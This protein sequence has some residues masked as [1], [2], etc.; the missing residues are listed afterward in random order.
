MK[1]ANKILSLLLALIMVFSLVACGGGG[2]GNDD[3]KGGGDSSAPPAG[4]TQAVDPTELGDKDNG[5]G[6]YYNEELGYTYGATFKSDTPITFTSFF[7]D[8]DA[9]PLKDSWRTGD[10]VFSKIAELTNVTLDIE[11]VNNASY[12]ERLNLAIS[13][14]DAPNIIPKVYSETAY[15]NG[16]GI[17]PVS[18]YVQ[19]MP[20]YLH[21]LNTYE[22]QNE[23]NT[24]LQEDGKYY[25]LPGLKEVALQDYT[26]LMRDDIFAA[27]GY[28]IKAL[29]KDW[30]WDEFTDILIGVKKYM[31]DNG[32]C[33]A[34]D[35][36]W[37]DR[38]C[39]A[40]SGYGQG[41]SLL[42]L[43]ASTYGIYSGWG[44][45]SNSAGLYFDFD[46]DEFKLSATSDAYKQYMTVVQRLVSEGI[47]DPETWTQDDDVADGKFYRGETVVHTT[48]R[49]S[50]TVQNDGL[51]SQ[52][53]EG[54]FSTYMAVIPKGTNNY[55]AEKQRLECGVCISSN[56][57]KNM[58]EAEFL[59]LM[60][61]VDW[62]WYSD[63]G[64]T[65]TKWGIEGVTYEKTAD[66]YQLLPNW[67]CGGL[68]IPKTDDSQLDMRL[69]LGYACGN[70]MYPGTRE[71]LT[72]N[73]SAELRDYYERMANYRELKQIDPAVAMS[74]DDSEMLNIWATPLRDTI[75]NWTI[76]FAMGLKDVNADWDTY[77]A[78]VEAQNAANVVNMYNDY[79]KK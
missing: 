51:K 31:V 41:G 14:G 75:N 76:N 1:K 60:R 10:G 68:S 28:D 15:V 49:A 42:N 24:L 56:A 63:E 4:P 73:F 13:S 47:L 16:G 74:E 65:L 55:Q 48:N 32:M 17:V 36:I 44:I 33:K 70:F 40:T 54:N 25:R 57:Q 59:R 27:A 71:L 79:Y 78:E 62:L 37:S 69:E 6:T 72:S 20:N 39:G 21:M 23:V 77:V 58:S 9:Y 64:L 19:Y 30:T 12:N 18:D 8:N 46:A 38:W 29:E 11:I 67:Y 53:G 66:G 5:D 3:S 35:Y 61:F 50:V 43:I 52:L 26:L 34:G 45:T 7:N 2:G 22:L